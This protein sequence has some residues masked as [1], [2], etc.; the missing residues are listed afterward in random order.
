MQSWLNEPTA[1][2]QTTFT[3]VGASLLYLIVVILLGGF[4]PGDAS[5]TVYPSMMIAH[6]R[7]ACA[8]PSMSLFAVPMAAPGYAVVTAFLQ[9]VLRLGFAQPF[10]TMA[11]LGAGCS[12]AAGVFTG[13]LYSPGLYSSMLHL[14]VISW[15]SL[16]MCTHYL[17]GATPLRGRR[18][19]WVAP[20]ALALT[21]PVFMAVQEYFHPQDQLALALALL[22]IGAWL[23]Q[24]AG[25]AGIVLA[26]AF[27]TQQYT[28][29][30]MI[31]VII[32]SVGAERRRLV[33]GFALTLVV[34]TTLVG[35][36]LGRAAVHAT[37]LGT[38]HSRIKF[39]TWMY[40]FHL[41][42]FAGLIISRVLPLVMTAILA[43]WAVRR[44]PDLAHDA[45]FILGLLALAFSL[46]VLL[47]INLFGYYLLATGA[48]M[49]LR[50]VVARRS[51]RGTVWLLVTILVAFPRMGVWQHLWP[52]EP[53]WLTQ[54][55]LAPSAFTL[56]LLSLLRTMKSEGTRATAAPANLVTPEG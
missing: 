48:T 56:T 32:A 46:R 51:Y 17:L 11:A 2:W 21:P 7:L 14:S 24:R 9:W 4:Q 1:W 50:D 18:R 28:I 35:F 31:V 55:I 40:E 8:Y 30:A 27:A 22:A 34:V 20:F 5:E 16:I 26:L 6:G 49:V 36:F 38:G 42:E 52:S 3:L 44:R 23:R 12:H 29:L 19:A 41:P 37:L 39:G 53:P 25:L 43:W 45:E 15:I 10:P 47:E 33:S 54:V 13:W